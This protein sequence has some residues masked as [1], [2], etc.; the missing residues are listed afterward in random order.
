[1][2]LPPS[3]PE[4]T[5]VAEEDKGFTTLYSGIDLTGW[6]GSPEH[7]TI[8]PWRLQH[9]GDGGDLTTTKSFGKFELMVDTKCEDPNGEIF[10]MI[11]GEKV[12]IPKG[13]GKWTRFVTSGNGGTISLGSTTKADFCNMY[14]R[15]LQR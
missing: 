4:T 14:I 8:Q 9:D 12:P 1:M 3:S 15:P 7:W 6:E 13:N 10:L 11:D 2:E 5:R